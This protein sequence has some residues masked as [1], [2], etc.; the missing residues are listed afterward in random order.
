MPVLRTS[1]GERELIPNSGMLVGR[2]P[3]C[4]LR[5]NNPQVSAEHAS[6]RWTGEAWELRDLHSRNGTAVNGR[7]VA[8][9]EWIELKRGASIQFSSAETWVLV[10]AS[11]P[12]LMAVRRSDGATVSSE[13]SLLAIPGEDDPI[14]TIFTGPD[15]DW[16]AESEGHSQVV[17][18]GDAI[19]VGDDEWQVYL[20]EGVGKTIDATGVVLL[21]DE[22]KLRFSVS[23]DREHIELVAAYGERSIDLK[24]RAHHYLTLTLAQLRQKDA[25]DANVPESEQGWIYTDD[26]RRMVGMTRN[27]MNVAVHRSRRQFADAG[28]LDAAN[29]IERRADTSELRLGI[30]SVE[31]TIP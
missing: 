29:L 6:I 8:P 4:G 12:P 27:Q 23:R 21:L 3:K 13:S 1:D 30:S 20:P 14:V 18:H 26:L 24:A 5:I 9:G 10:D 31:I 22:V 16:H 7:R 15:G 11:P 2:S 28:I 19:S 25:A 17:T